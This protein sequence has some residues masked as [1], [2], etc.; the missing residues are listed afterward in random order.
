MRPNLSLTGFPV[1]SEEELREGGGEDREARWGVCQGT[2]GHGTPMGDVRERYGDSLGNPQGAFGGLMGSTQ[3]HMC[4]W[5]ICSTYMHH[6]VHDLQLCMLAW[7]LSTLFQLA[8]I[9]M[10]D[11]TAVIYLKI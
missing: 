6:I 11:K 8:H 4:I 5:Y 9:S 3:G 1:T 10:P 2:H 7:I